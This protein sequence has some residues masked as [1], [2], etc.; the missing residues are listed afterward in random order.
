ML[1]REEN[2]ED[3]AASGTICAVLL[4]PRNR[5]EKL[6]RQLVILLGEKS[7]CAE[8]EM[9]HWL[10]LTLRKVSGSPNRDFH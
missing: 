4:A 3:L 1:S 6:S 10:I 8:A 7:S 5:H 2:L 9:F